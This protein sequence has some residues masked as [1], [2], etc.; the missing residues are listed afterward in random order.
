M[1]ITSKH[2]GYPS[3]LGVIRIRLLIIFLLAATALA[4][5]VALAQYP[6]GGLLQERGFVVVL[7]VTLPFG[8]CCHVTHFSHP[9]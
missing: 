1:Q 7:E 5:F 2:S 8:N 3:R 4:T 6:H 9:R